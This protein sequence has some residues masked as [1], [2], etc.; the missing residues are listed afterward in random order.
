[1]AG[2]I[3]KMHNKLQT[4][5]IKWELLV[6]LLQIRYQPKIVFLAKISNLNNQNK[7]KFRVKELIMTC[8]C[9]FQIF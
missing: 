7:V 9:L 3:F 1:M 6:R 8:C 5:F 2:L 4:E